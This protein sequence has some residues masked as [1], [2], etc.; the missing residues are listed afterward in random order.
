MSNLLYFL[1]IPKT[2]GTSFTI[3]LKKFFTEHEI[4]P[5]EARV[6]V[7]RKKKISELYVL[8]Y[9][10]YKLI[11]GHF[12]N[13]ITTYLPKNTTTL[14][15][16]RDPIE[17]CISHYHHLLG[18][19]TRIHYYK[20]KIIRNLFQGNWNALLDI[21]ELSAG[22]SNLQVKHIGI[23]QL[24]VTRKNFRSEDLYDFNGMLS[25][26]TDQELEA[27][28]INAKKN[29]KNYKLVGIQEYFEQTQILFYLLFDKN[30][31]SIARSRFMV[32]PNRPQKSDLG[33]DIIKRLTRMNSAD[34]ELYREGVEL[35]KTS[36]I[37]EITKLARTM[38]DTPPLFE[39]IQGAIYLLSK[40]EKLRQ[41]KPMLRIFYLY[42]GWIAR[43]LNSVFRT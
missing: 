11:H 14:T 5:L 36:Y 20:G 39:D 3:F 25:K 34:I 1:H 23:D 30:F 6:D 42:A 43:K 19:T 27:I 10:G 22:M 21:E 13:A 28:T 16:L 33:E 9:S 7:D 37:N 2:A 26:L 12:T 15:I 35:F 18:D 8:D 40:R 32:F 38:L 4:C 31:D 29:L 41:M 24:I 17:R